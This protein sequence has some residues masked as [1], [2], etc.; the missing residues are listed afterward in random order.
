LNADLNFDKLYDQIPF[1]KKINRPARPSRN[2]GRTPSSRSSGKDEE[3]GDPSG[4]SKKKNDEVSPIARAIIRPL[5]LVRKGR[6]TYS[7]NMRTVVPG[8]TPQTELLGL[9]SGFDAPGWGFVAGL[10]P[11]IRTLT[12]A[13]RDAANAGNPVSDDWLYQNREWITQN[14]FLNQ[15]VIQEYTQNYEGRL[16]IE[17]FPDFRL[18]IEGNRS[19]TENYTESFKIFDKEDPDVDF[20]HRIPNFGGRLTVSYN[21]LSTIFQGSD[22]EIKSLFA[23][24]QDYRPIISQRLGTGI[25]AD[26]NLAAEGYTDGYG[27][28]HQDVLIPAFIA[29]YSGDDPNTID[30]NPFNTSWKPN[31]R[32]TY[33]GLSKLKAF[34]DVFSSFN[35]SHGYKSTFTINNYET[36]LYYLRALRDNPDNGGLDTETFDF[37]P[38]IEIPDVVVQENF[39]PLFAIDMTF[40]NGMSMNFDYKQARTL[41]LN[42]TGKQLIQTGSS[43][44]ATGF[45]Y[46]MS[47]VDIGFLTGNKKKK[48]RGGAAEPDPN[49]TAPG[50]RPRQNRAGGRLNTNDLDLQFNFSY[51]DDLTVTQKLDSDIFEKTRGSISVSLS[52]SAEYQLNKN[53]S[54]RLFVDY[55]RV[56]PRTSIGFP[57]TDA[58]GGIVVR[59]QLN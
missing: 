1:L 22:D 31:W 26:P 17:P 55:R 57:R 25:H 2:T 23:T 13:E 28:N 48:G 44:I 3:V 41:A 8:F 20:A 27:R 32:M 58:S 4:A 24:F 6:F 14:V 43:E 49:A 34:K 37:F 40:Q 53:L 33:N 7:E 29:A 42:V 45:G 30:L 59:F 18:E 46:R 39:A 19:F 5:L 54:L 15:D 12:D 52:P 38:R 10:Q 47:G 21:A 56:I 50:G 11:K 16:T 36:S 35:I 51:R 9:S